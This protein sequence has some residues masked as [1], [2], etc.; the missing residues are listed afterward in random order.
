MLTV[1]RLSLLALRGG[2]AAVLLALAAAAGAEELR[3]LTVSPGAVGESL[4]LETAC[5]TFSWAA[6]EGARGYELVVDE[7]SDPDP[8]EPALRIEIAGAATSYTPAQARCL[9]PARRYAWSVRALRESGVAEWSEPRFF[10]VARTPPPSDLERAIERALD[11]R[12][13][14]GRREAAGAAPRRPERRN[15]GVPLAGIVAPSHFTPAPCAGVFS[16]VDAASPFCAWIEQSV[17]DGLSTACAVDGPAQRYCPNNP[18]TRQQLA[19]MLEKGVQERWSV[20]GNAGTSAETHF[21]GTTDNQSLE[22]KVFGQ[23]ALLLRPDLSGNLAPSLI[24][25]FELNSVTAGVI[26]AVVAGGGGPGSVNQVTDHW[27]AVAGGRGNLAGNGDADLDAQRDAFVGGG[28]HNSASGNVATVGGGVFNVASG[29]AATVAGGGSG[30]VPNGG[31]IASSSYATV[32]G[33]ASNQATGVS[34]LVAG[35]FD[36]IAG[37]TDAAVVGGYLN[38]AL[39]YRSFIGGGAFNTASGLASTVA[40]GG[41]AGAGPGGG[42]TASSSYA[43]VGGGAF[44]TASGVS[45]LVAGGFENEASANDAVVAGGFD[46]AASATRSFVGGGNNNHAS[47]DYGVIGGGQNNNAGDDAGTTAD[48][49]FA[50]VGGGTANTASGYAASVLG[51]VANLANAEGGVVGG[52]FLNVAGFYG[53]VPGGSSNTAFGSHSFAG[54]LRAKAIGD[55]TFV[56]ADLN[57]FDFSAG[58]TNSFK[59]R[60]TGGVRFVLGIDPNNDGATTWSCWVSAGDGAWNCSSDRNLKENLVEVDGA[61]VLARLEMLPIYRWNAK[62]QEVVVPHVGPMA[63]DFRAAFGLGSSELMIN[64]MDL[65]GVAL[66]AVRELSARAAASAA[67]LAATRVRLAAA[68]AALAAFAARLDALEK[69]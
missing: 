69:R 4:R 21:L 19:M 46:N 64:G 12:F 47:D 41:V 35:G 6:V 22:L 9:P 26:G 43:T 10:S 1:P 54:G 37:S 38:Q 60:A 34:S 27:G 52:G 2:I 18:V 40:G 3:P 24:G 16:D 63:Q 15:P 58:A 49:G 45:S 25:G 39:G 48:R 65:D 53:S 8:A 55:G 68:E 14:D 51:G 28:Y 31:N 30:V 62:G 56:W 61:E 5:P 17:A 20:E 57:D 36:N 33:G 23:R 59:V 67:E 7:V 50:T 32:G 13:G 66:A 44:N 42:N 29:M 11:R